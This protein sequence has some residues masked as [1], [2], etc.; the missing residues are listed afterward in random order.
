MTEYTTK[1]VW[2]GSHKGELSCSN[3]AIMPFS[4]PADMYG[5]LGILTPEDA[6]TS[7]GI[8]RSDL[9]FRKDRFTPQDNGQSL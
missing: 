3:G 1:A 8:P 2:T 5:E 6:F 7:Q 9:N 4:A